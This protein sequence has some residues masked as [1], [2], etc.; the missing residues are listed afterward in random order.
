MHDPTDALTRKLGPLPAAVNALDAAGRHALLELVT[1]AE[2]RQ[3]DELEAAFET[4]LSHLP[5][6]LRGTVRKMIRP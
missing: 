5:R 2:Q 3:S 6:L 1:R 4:A